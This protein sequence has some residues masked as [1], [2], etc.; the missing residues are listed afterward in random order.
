MNPVRRLQRG[1]VL[2][3][4]L[5]ILAMG[6][7]WYLVSRLNDN[8]AIAAT[9]RKERNAEVLKRAKQALIGYVAAQALNS[10]E[11][12]PGALP[13][14][15]AAGYFDTYYGDLATVGDWSQAQPLQCGYPA[16]P[17]S[18]GDYLTVT[19]PLPTPSPGHGRYYVTAVTYQGE[20][21]YG[22]KRDSG[23]LAA[24]DPAV[25]PACEE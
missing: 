25:L 14:P 24:R 3:L 10:G 8:S 15:E 5:M 19:D 17:P 20:R 4:M 21:R 12:N 7:T 2:L 18:V 11:D 22:R 16:S 9:L 6:S 23:I 1:Q 13:C